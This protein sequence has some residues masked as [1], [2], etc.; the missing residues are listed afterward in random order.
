MQ[1]IT[2]CVCTNR[3]GTQKGTESVRLCLGPR[4]RE[5]LKVADFDPAR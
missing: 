4:D 5:D 2:R 3:T 1:D